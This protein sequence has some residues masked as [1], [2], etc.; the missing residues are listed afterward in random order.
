MRWVLPIKG[1]V[2]YRCGGALDGH[3]ITIG[4]MDGGRE[5][6]LSVVSSYEMNILPSGA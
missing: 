4:I 3:E 2:Y 5:I 1:G 6:L